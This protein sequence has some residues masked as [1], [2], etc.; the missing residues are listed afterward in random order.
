VSPSIISVLTC[1]FTRTNY[2]PGTTTVL[3][4]EQKKIKISIFFFLWYED[5]TK[6]LQLTVL[7]WTSTCRGSQPW[8]RAD[9]GLRL[10]DHDHQKESSPVWPRHESIQSSSSVLVYSWMT[11]S[12]Y[13][14]MVQRTLLSNVVGKRPAS[15]YDKSYVGKFLST[16]QLIS[17]MSDPYRISLHD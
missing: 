2:V 6:T 15:D 1:P 11:M 7:Y 16:A 9:K 3:M 14:Q 17:K 12:N 13:T 10:K 4:K 5:I 8:R